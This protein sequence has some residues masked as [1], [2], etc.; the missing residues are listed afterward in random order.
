MRIIA[1]LFKGRILA[2]PKS[3]ARPSSEMLRGALFNICQDVKGQSFLDLFAG[4]G[5]I[6]FEALSRGASHVTFVDKDKN[7]LAA[8]R[9]NGALLNVQDKITIIS[10]E[11]DKAL[12][13]LGLFDIIFLDPPYNLPVHPYI[14]KV[15][16]HLKTNGHLFVEDRHGSP[17]E[18]TPLTLQSTR[19]FGDSRLR[20]YMNVS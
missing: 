13:T 17:T 5:A 19:R 7:S 3:E 1:G 9:K 12:K 6:G 11:A 10:L 18:E 4:S 20:H 8:I 14:V 2:G 16:S 15:E